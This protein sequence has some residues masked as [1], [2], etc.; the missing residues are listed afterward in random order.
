M[1][2]NKYKNAKKINRYDKYVISAFNMCVSR[3]LIVNV[4]HKK[5]RNE[6]LQL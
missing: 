5:E 2:R 4:V 3:E 1:L 6:T